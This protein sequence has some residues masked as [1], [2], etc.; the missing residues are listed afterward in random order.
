MFDNN[1]ISDVRQ[2]LNTLP[3]FRPECVQMFFRSHKPFA[4]FGLGNSLQRRGG[5]AV[6]LY[7]QFI[8]AS[9][10]ALSKQLTMGLRAIVSLFVLQKLK[11]FI[12]LFV[13]VVVYG[14]NVHSPNAEG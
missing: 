7:T 11:F 2:S 10:T 14:L 9:H 5:Y 1:I 6:S 4:H 3:A 12:R 8:N 13:L